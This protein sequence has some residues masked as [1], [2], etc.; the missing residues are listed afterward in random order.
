MTGCAAHR[1]AE[2]GPDS[3]TATPTST[4]LTVTWTEYPDCATA[5]RA[6]DLWPPTATSADTTV[7]VSLYTENRYGCFGKHLE[8]SADI[9][10]SEPVTG[11]VES[12]LQDVST[13]YGVASTVKTDIN[14]G[15][16]S[17]SAF[18]GH[19]DYAAGDVID[20]LGA[21]F[22]FWCCA[23]DGPN[24]G[25]LTLASLPRP[26]LSLRQLDRPFRLD[27]V[28]APCSS[29]PVTVRSNEPIEGA[30]T[31]PTDPSAGDPNFDFYRQF[32]YDGKLRL[33]VGTY[34]ATARSTAMTADCSST[35][36]DLS[37]SIVLAVH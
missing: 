7:V 9:A 5:P 25:A 26:A 4:G 14:H 34:L 6:V 24:T 32:M 29:Q 12:Y 18:A 33:P 37:T 35:A 13:G 30:A 10:L 1:G 2:V 31:V 28:P 20:D 15:E 36:L 16:A 21:Q 23:A 3:L 27:N 22:N 19:D 17:L 8:V 11:T